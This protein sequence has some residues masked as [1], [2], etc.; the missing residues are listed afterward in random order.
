VAQLFRQLQPGPLSGH[1][2]PIGSPLYW[3]GDIKEKDRKA[4]AFNSRA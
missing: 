1:D 3:I 4:D 2:R